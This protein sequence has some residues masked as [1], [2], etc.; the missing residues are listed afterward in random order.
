M[1]V[2]LVLPTTEEEVS[3]PYSFTRRYFTVEEYELLVNAGVLAG[4]ERVEL[5]EGELIKMSPVNLA[6][7]LAVNRLTYLL[8]TRLAQRAILSIQ[9]PV[10]LAK[11]SMPQPDVAL[12]RL[13]E[14]DYRSGL[15]GPEDILLIIEVAD[16]SVEYDRRG[17]SLLY[18]RAG[19]QEYWIV[20]LPQKV[21]EVYRQPREGSYR[22]ILRLTTGDTADLLAF[23]DVTLSV[24][25]ILGTEPWAGHEAQA[26]ET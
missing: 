10:R 14:D 3:E 12:W 1:V 6:H 20:N 11:R 21:L 13:H 18:A 23:P 22:S 19:I 8:A 7:V 16:S 5:L 9:N 24:G 26:E 15:P 2:E 17:K 4:D 25:A